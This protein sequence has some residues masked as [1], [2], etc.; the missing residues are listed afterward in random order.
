MA[1]RARGNF[2]EL[3]RPILE[4][5]DRVSRYRTELARAAAE[6]GSVATGGSVPAAGSG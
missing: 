3:K 2:D 6:L 4:D 1:G 5:P